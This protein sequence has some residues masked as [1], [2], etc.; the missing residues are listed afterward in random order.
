MIL[1]GFGWFVLTILV[2][3]AIDEFELECEW[4]DGQGWHLNTVRWLV[5]LGGIAMMASSCVP[6]GAMT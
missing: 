5:V 2:L 4:W 3:V 1:K 6:K